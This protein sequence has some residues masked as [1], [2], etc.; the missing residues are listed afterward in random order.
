VLL[1]AL[2]LLLIAVVIG[3]GLVILGCCLFEAVS[4]CLLVGSA[5]RARLLRKARADPDHW[6]GW[7]L[8]GFVGA[9]VLGAALWL[10]GWLLGR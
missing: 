3:Q 1:D 2:G 6:A 5:V 7:L 8:D 9:V 10:L 4:A